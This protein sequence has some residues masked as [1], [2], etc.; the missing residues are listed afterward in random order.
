MRAPSLFLALTLA[1]ALAS[2]AS[3]A[4]PHADPARIVAPTPDDPRDQLFPVLAAGR[5]TPFL[6]VWQQGRHYYEQQTADLRALRLGADGAPLSSQPI[7]IAPRNASQEHPRVAADGD[8]FVVVWQ[9]LR[10]GGDWDVYAARID[11]DGRV[12][13]P[14]GILVAGG[15]GNQAMPVVAP[16]DDGVLIAWQDF[17]DGRFYQ[18]HAAF[19][20]PSGK[21]EG[22]QALRYRDAA[23][24]GFYAYTP[25]FGFGAQ[26]LATH[27]IDPKV[28]RGGELSLA[29]MQGG[30]LLAWTDESNW[31]PG[32]GMLRRF[33]RL[34]A[35]GD[36]VTATDASRGTANPVGTDAGRF[37]VNGDTAL[38]AGWGAAGRARWVATGLRF[39]AGSATPLPNPNQ[40]P[41]RLGS[42]WAPEQTALLFGPLFDVEGPVAAAFANGHYLVVTPGRQGTPGK[43]AYRLYGS[44]LRA[45][46]TRM[47]GPDDWPVLH[48][49]AHPPANPV[50]AAAGNGFLLAFEEED[51]NGRRR[52]RTQ[53]LNGE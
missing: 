36:T 5:Q 34:E 19:L 44:R 15:A 45:D 53:L 42:G 48:E 51:D 13:D 27:D 50:L 24:K 25:G 10:E 14:D 47:D 33:A 20:R 49:G 29:R 9:E 37:A 2:P 26:P 31:P 40:E 8:R 7:R 43:H 16:A 12:L 1:L 22:R 21:V 39:K 32:G 6:L 11:A 3:A 35:K 41:K 17:A 52:I 30:W 18:I 4:A 23:P 38:Y 28:L 46:G